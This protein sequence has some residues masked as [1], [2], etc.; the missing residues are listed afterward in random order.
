MLPIVEIRDILAIFATL[1][2]YDFVGEVDGKSSPI[3][4]SFYI[5][6]RPVIRE[7]AAEAVFALWP[8]SFAHERLMDVIAPPYRTGSMSTRIRGYPLRIAFDGG[9]YIGRFLDYRG[10]YEEGVIRKLA[11]LLSPGMGFVDVGANIGLH[12]L[13]AAHKVGAS[14]RVLAL[15]PQRLVYERLKA[16]IVLNGLSQ[17]T[18]LNIAVGVT[19]SELTLYQLSDANDGLATLALTADERS[20]SHETVHVVRLDSL[21]NSVFG[22][23]LPDV[24]KIDVEGA[25]LEVLRGAT[26]AF[27]RSQPNYVFVECIERHLN[28]F[29]ATSGMLIRW[30]ADAGFQ[31]TGLR[32]GMWIP[33]RPEDGVSMDLM[34]TRAS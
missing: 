5:V 24:I 30:L 25:E 8:F 3:F 16:N 21:I 15:E 31:V 33:V 2:D 7:L 19:E 12:C 13:V 34:A 4:A 1:R 9:S 10:I 22:D 23:A 18:A 6:I 20:S 27:T 26:N 29:N 28:R 17:V 14:G 11:S 32:A